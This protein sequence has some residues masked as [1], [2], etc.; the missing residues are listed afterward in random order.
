[1]VWRGPR[2][3]LVQRPE[4]GRWAG[5]WEF[6]HAPPC[7]GETHNAAARRILPAQTRITAEP[8]RELLTLVHGVTRFRITLT[9]V[10]ARYRAGT[11]RSPFYRRGCWVLLGAL[12]DYPVSSPQR[13]IA[14]AL[15]ARAR[16][17]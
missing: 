2:V 11:F 15:V 9:C 16:S 5:L 4:R 17:E 13:R 7:P 8:E 12:A 10:E 14:Q 1:V 6:P 3:L